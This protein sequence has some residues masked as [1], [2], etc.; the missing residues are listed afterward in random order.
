[1]PRSGSPRRVYQPARMCL[2]VWGGRAVPA[3]GWPCAAAA[4][5]R[6][7][8]PCGVCAAHLQHIAPATH[9]GRPCA[10]S[11]APKAPPAHHGRPGAHQRLQHAHDVPRPAQARTGRGHGGPL[12]NSRVGYV[13][14][15]EGCVRGA[16]G[17]RDGP[18]TPRAARRGGGGVLR[19][20][21]RCVWIARELAP[22]Q[23]GLTPT[24]SQGG[25]SGR[26]D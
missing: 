17:V 9:P 2:G 8:L 25:T 3:V 7:G 13:G 1:M 11:A 18:R 14:V 19:R 21:L 10:S 5:R 12:R 4:R 22:A 20:M 6:V 26:C 16:C 15:R 24:H 23:F